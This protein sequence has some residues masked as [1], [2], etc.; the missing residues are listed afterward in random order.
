MISSKTHISTKQS[1]T[2]IKPLPLHPLP[3][4]N[5]AIGKWIELLAETNKT[6]FKII[7]LY[8]KKVVTKMG[9]F[10]ALT[11]LTTI[12]IDQLTNLSNEFAEEF[13][14]SPAKCP[15]Q[16]CRYINKNTSILFKHLEINH[17]LG[18]RYKCPYLDCGFKAVSRA[19]LNKHLQHIHDI[20]LKWYKCPHCDLKTKSS[21]IFINHLTDVLDPVSVKKYLSQI[22]YK[23]SVLRGWFQC[24]HCGFKTKSAH[25]LLGHLERMLNK[26]DQ[27]KYR[28]IIEHNDTNV[29]IIAEGTD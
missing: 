15:I 6:S 9:F 25:L 8:I 18:R 3:N 28:K 20:D 19:D 21:G 16:N 7:F 11:N 29:Y 27:N 17:N 5:E 22:N 14:K 23:S 1:K 10:R 4:P 13:W 24:S 2:R 12:P 26:Y